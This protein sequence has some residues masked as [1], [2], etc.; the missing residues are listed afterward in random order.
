MSEDVIY[1]Q[2]EE[3]VGVPSRLIAFLFGTIVSAFLIAIW[4][5]AEGK[6]DRTS[7]LNNQDTDVEVDSSR[8]EIKVLE[9]E[10]VAL[11][12][13]VERKEALIG[14][15]E[16]RNQNISSELATVRERLEQS[17][18]RQGAVEVKLDML[19]KD[20]EKLATVHTS[21][22]AV[23]GSYS[24]KSDALNVRSSPNS[25][26]AE[27]IV[28]NLGNGSELSVTDISGNWFSI[29]VRGWVFKNHVEA[30]K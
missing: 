11:K 2:S 6:F 28:A 17:Q 7:D 30:T 25:E 18:I 20:N 21:T 22:E 15:L 23:I 3:H 16:G 24:V 1:R 9:R 4:L 8:Q 12:S 27:N 26:S 13:E 29:V 14:D 10:I 5:L 19:R